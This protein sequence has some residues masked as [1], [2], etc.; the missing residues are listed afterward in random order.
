MFL[1][2]SQLELPKLLLVTKSHNNLFISL[3][4]HISVHSEQLLCLYTMRKNPYGYF[5]K[6]LNQ[7]YTEI[8]VS[9]STFYGD[10]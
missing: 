2:L 1:I 9:I 10:Q 6:D 3:Q 7:K 8:N 4:N 5:A